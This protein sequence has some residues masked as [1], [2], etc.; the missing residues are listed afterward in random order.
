MTGVCNCESCSS[1]VSRVPRLV[2][3]VCCPCSEEGEMT[4]VCWEGG[5]NVSCTVSFPL[6]VLS[7]TNRRL[8][9]FTARWADEKQGKTCLN[10]FRK[11]S[12][13]Q[14]YNHGCKRE[15]ETDRQSQQINNS[16]I[17]LDK[18]GAK[19]VEDD[20]EIILFYNPPSSKLSYFL[21]NKH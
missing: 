14:A 4:F 10:S 17:Q 9:R 16:D 15:T 20:F 5:I 3:P 11:F 6:H 21:I 7:E 1:I 18:W 12:F 8:V 13:S 2:D 19:F